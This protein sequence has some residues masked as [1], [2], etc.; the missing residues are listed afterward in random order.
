MVFGI[1]VSED[2]SRTKSK[3]SDIGYISEF[4]GLN[5]S[6]ITDDQEF[7][8]IPIECQ[9]QSEQQYKD[10]TIGYSAHS[11]LE[12]KK[13]KL[14]NI[15][16]SV[17]GRYLDKCGNAKIFREYLSYVMNISP[18]FSTAKITEHDFE[19]GRI[20]IAKYDLYES[21][22]L[23]SKIPPN[24]K[25]FAAYKNYFRELYNERE[26]IFPTENLDPK[27]IS[28][29]EI[30]NLSDDPRAY[31]N[32]FSELSISLKRTKSIAEEIYSKDSQDISKRI[33][34]ENDSHDGI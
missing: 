11:N 27:Y 2:T 24:S 30:P 7:F 31:K 26:N 6:I 33:D 3:H 15:P 5:L 20:I 17:N 29:G 21:F 28:M 19:I 10:S 34:D 9:L 23:I 4:I 16:K 25:T 1:S 32:F 13:P 12:G 22:R 14:K 8:V 18:Q